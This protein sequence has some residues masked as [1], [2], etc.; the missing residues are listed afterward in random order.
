MG[1]AAG[2]LTLGVH[3]A[4]WRDRARL[5]R[6]QLTALALL[7]GLNILHP[8]A[9][10]WPLGFPLP[11]AQL[12]VFPFFGAILLVAGG[13]ITIALG[14]GLHARYGLRPRPGEA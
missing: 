10:G 8:I 3:L 6:D 12:L 13:L 14:V 5:V 2:L 1:F 9:F 4:V 7:L 11:N